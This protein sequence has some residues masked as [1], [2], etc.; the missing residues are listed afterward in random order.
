MDA[1]TT[2]FSQLT[3]PAVCKIL[4]NYRQSRARLRL[5]FGDAATGRDWM[6]END[7]IGTVGRSTG[8]QPIPLLIK[9]TGS[10]GGGAILDHCIVKIMDVKTKT[11]LYQHP[12]YHQ[13]TLKVVNGGYCWDVLAN[14]AGHASFKTEAAARRYVEFLQGQRMA[15]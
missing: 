11:T 1:K 15:K 10:L 8:S 2:H 4:E 6:E 14:G 12:Q 3:N 9:S 5:F 7:T 13:P